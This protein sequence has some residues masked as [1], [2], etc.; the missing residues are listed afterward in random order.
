MRKLQLQLDTLHVETFATSTADPARGTVHGHYSQLG[1]CD[2]RVATCQLGGTCANG[3][4]TA[5][6][7]GTACL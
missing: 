5:G 4:G 7:T 3:C 1:T 6:C 2:G